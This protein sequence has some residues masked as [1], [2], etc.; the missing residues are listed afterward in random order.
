MFISGYRGRST[1]HEVWVFGMVDTSHDPALGYMEIVPRRDAATLL[2]IINT[3]VAPGT[4]V[5]S[6]Q[7]RAYKR[8]SSYLSRHREF[9]NTD[10]DR[11]NRLVLWTTPVDFFGSHLPRLLVD[12]SFSWHSFK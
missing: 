11:Q 1:Q 9:S 12:S 7:W 2:P 4:T 5:W 6:D 3:H 8:L 10:S